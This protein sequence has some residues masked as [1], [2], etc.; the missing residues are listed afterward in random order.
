MKILSTFKKTGIINSLLIILILLLLSTCTIRYNN[1]FLRTSGDNTESK[2]NPMLSP[3]VSKISASATHTLI[4][5][6]NNTVWATGRNGCGQHGVGDNTN[7]STPVEM[8]SDV[9]DIKAGDNYNLILKNDNTL[10]AT[11]LNNFGQLGVGDNLNRS[12]PIEVTSDVKSMSA[13][14][15]FSL[16]LKNDNT[17]WAVGYNISGQFGV[18]DN[19]NRST[20]IEVTSDVKDM[21]AGQGHTLILK[22]ND[23]L[24]ATG[25][26]PYG[27]LGVG[28]KVPHGPTIGCYTNS[29]LEVTSNVKKMSGGGMHTLILKND[30][31][32]WATGRNSEGQLG[33]GDKVPSGSN[34]YTASLVEVTS[35]V[36]DMK[37]GVWH[38]LILKND[39]TLWATG[40]N[41]EGQLGRW[42]YH[43][44]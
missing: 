28:D 27:Q 40:R 11:G 6:E 24:W 38:S 35:D 10:W 39:N 13:G 8:T 23:T 1:P 37:A 29:P 9:K 42:R 32:L 30:N 20:P 3:L 21:S 36:K 19:T 5:D 41:S 16:I 22:N 44:Q 14:L 34:A 25:S 2:S 15:G 12:T 43:K 17:L 31:T 33:V 7:R 26:N 18:G 4:L